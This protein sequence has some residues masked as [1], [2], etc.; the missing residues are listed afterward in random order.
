MQVNFTVR[1]NNGEEFESAD[2][3][4]TVEDSNGD[5]QYLAVS[6]RS[7]VLLTTVSVAEYPVVSFYYFSIFIFMFILV[8]IETEV[9]DQ[10]VLLSIFF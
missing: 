6:S 2:V 10:L 7:P 1:P 8:F 4:V 9:F 3:T 5:L